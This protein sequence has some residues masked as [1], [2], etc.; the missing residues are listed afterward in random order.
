MW[1]IANPFRMTT[2]TS[3]EN[4]FSFIQSGGELGKL[5]RAKDWSITALGNPSTWPPTLCTLVGMMLEN[6]FGMLI[7]W[8]KEYIQIYNDGFR[9]ILGTIKHPTALGIS[10]NE[11]YA[12]IWD[13]IEPMFASVMQGNPV[14]ITDFEMPLNRHGCL[15]TCYFDF[16]C[17]PVRLDNGEVGGLLMTVL[18]T[19]NKK[20]AETE[21]HE[22]KDQLKF[23]IEAAQ[24][25][26]WELNPLSNKFTANDRLK[27]WFGLRPENEIELHHALNVIAEEDRNRVVASI[28]KSLEYH[29]GGIYQEQ[30]SIIHPRS[31]KETIVRAKGRAWFNDEKVAYRFNGILEDVTEEVISQEKIKESEVFNKT[32]LESSPDCVKV[33]DLNGAITFINLNGVCILEGENK[34]FFLNRDWLTL[35]D[36]ET[37]PTIKNAITQALQGRNSHFQAKAATV[38][39]TQKWWDVIVTPIIDTKGNI[40]SVLAT[41]RDVTEIK[42]SQE[43]IKENEIRFR[44]LADNMSQLAWMSNEKGNRYWYNQRW[45]DYTGT[46]FEDMSIDGWKKVHHPERVDQV[47][48]K[49]QNCWDSGEIWEDTVRLKSKQGNFRWFLSRA[50]PVKDDKGKTIRWFGTNTDITE[51]KE[52]IEKLNTS[53]DKLRLY[54]N[55][56]GNTNDAVLITEAEPIDFPGPKILYVNNALCL[57]TGYTEEE[58]IG[59]TACMFQGAATNRKELDRIRIAQQNKIPVKAELINY[60]KNGEEFIVQTEIIPLLDEDGTLTHFVTVQKDITDQVVANKKIQES[61]LRFRQLSD[62]APMWVWMVDENV[63][64]LYANPQVLNFIGIEEVSQFT[65]N[66][67]E[68]VVHPD[69][70]QMVYKSFSEASL[71]QKEISFDLR[72]K[73]AI[74]GLYEWFFIKAVPRFE[75]RKFAGFIGTALNIQDQKS[76]VSLLE[77]RKALLEAFH[78][79]SNDGILLVDTKGAI[80]SYNHRFVEIWNMPQ[81]IVDAR[82]DNAALDFAMTQLESPEKFMERIILLYKYP[83][84]NSKDEL[85]FK[86]GKIIERHGFPVKTQE[87]SNYAWSWTFRDITEIKKTSAALKESE[88]TFRKLSELM[89]EK[90]SRTDGEGNAVYYNQSWLDYT[91]LSFEELKDWGWGKVVH[92]DEKDELNKQWTESLL[93]GKNFEMEFRILNRNGE[94]RWHL[95]RSN[96]LKDENGK[97]NNWLAA[98]TEIQKIKEEEQRKGE[99][100]KMVS[101]ELKT[102]VTSIKGYVQLLLSMLHSNTEANISAIPFKPTLE[103]VDKQILRLTRLITE[104]LDLSRLEENK[105]DLK[106][107]TFDLNTLVSETIQDLQHTSTSH[108]INLSQNFGANVTGDRD[109]IQQVL[110]NFINNAIKYSPDKKL[111]EIMVSEAENNQVKISVKDF[112]I[113]INKVDQSKIYE[114]FY[115]V[116][117]KNEKNFSGFGIGLYIAKE[118]IERHQGTIRLESKIGQGSTFSFSLPI[119]N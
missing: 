22:S 69:D 51:Q 104:M 93:N 41:S 62:Q 60:K 58:V 9:P 76:T 88:E 114:R 117:G 53:V 115:R 21:L 55:I 72:V 4:N 40:V 54:E 81:Y 103:R 13:T 45:Y 49:M 105:L 111:V 98:V 42:E 108:T 113:G 15:E 92:P 97:I 79:S 71:F 116:S 26:A 36:N 80:I 107:E 110:I 12:E 14:R 33:L 29:S 101:H 106:K 47:F 94:Y 78:E 28:Q 44:A 6:P 34:E 67:W 86:D 64:V 102:P 31:K 11:T 112:G 27:E 2:T 38:K 87:G 24:L 1:A 35:W 16:S 5:I 8:G 19:T 109:R 77:Y 73:N 48:Q 63:N 66:I 85:T 99:F 61:E 52:L 56:V 50:V 74:T 90:I 57:Q 7:C 43:L 70:I 18:E 37:K 30:Y 75:I 20:K 39:G 83:D 23:A 96:P 119:E 68:Q 91:G 89:P 82:D 95:C 118:I 100:I 84:Q 32:I 65:G 25:G 10:A 17:S 59:Q 46:S 3:A